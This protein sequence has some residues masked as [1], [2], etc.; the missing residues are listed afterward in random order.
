M[1]VSIRKTIRGMSRTDWLAAAVCLVLFS[2]YFVIIRRGIG[3]DD[4]SFYYTI[5]QRLSQGDRL[6]V[7]EWHVSQLSGLLLSVLYR[8][9]TAVTGGVDGILL[10]MRFVYAFCGFCIYWLLYVK[11]RR[12][13][14]WGLLAVA[15]FTIF[16]FF[17][18][19]TLNYITMTVQ[20]TAV[21]GA[22]VLADGRP[23]SVPTLLFAGI[24]LS[25]TVLA[26]PILAIA[27]LFY[28]VMVFANRIR[29]KCRPDSAKSRY[30]FILNVRVWRWIS[31]SVGACLIA[32]LL[33]LQIKSG[34]PNVI[35]NLP[36]L[37]TDSEY[38]FSTDGN[39]LFY[40]TK[41]IVDYLN[42]MY[43]RLPRWGLNCVWVASCVYTVLRRGLLQ[44]AS[45]GAQQ[46]Q[47]NADLHVRMLLLAA[48][49]LFFSLAFFR[50]LGVR[51]LDFTPIDIYSVAVRMYFCPAAQIMLFAWI[52]Y[53]LSREQSPHLFTNLSASLML[54][55]LTDYASDMVVA[56]GGVIAL[57]CAV[58]QFGILIR[59]MKDDVRALRTGNNH[60]FVR[61]RAVL[62]QCMAVCC[63]IAFCAWT[64]TYF[65]H[66]TIPVVEQ[67]FDVSGKRAAVDTRIEDGVYKGIY[68]TGKLNG[69]YQDILSD[70]DKIRA[71]CTG[72]VYVI[73]SKFPYL[74]MDL[75]YA[76]YSAW[77][78]QGDMGS[79]QVL[80]WL[81]NPSRK[82]QY[83]L[84]PDLDSLFDQPYPWYEVGEELPDYEKEANNLLRFLNRTAVYEI[85]QG[86]GGRILHIS[87]WKK[88][89]L[90]AEYL[91]AI[92][93]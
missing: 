46:T 40:S 29:Q 3:I 23:K 85:D 19:P 80:Y 88:G 53:N 15:S 68:T 89:A 14:T 43:G 77:Y 9:F 83:I 22:L 58:P 45:G 90:E 17:L 82:P 1:I 4:E 57:L 11:M 37:V 69:L 67:R 27:Y 31:L 63:V 34:I 93:H 59:E 56:L 21:F 60:L 75:P 74:Y 18:M 13:G 8:L 48:G 55:V 20:G 81:I 35:R 42:P 44:R 62:M 70:C 64:G 2:F 5:P 72:S 54:S 50:S 92:C 7:D 41:K 12:Y 47:S 65:Y 78:V 84:L 52:C 86:R 66:S 61:F 87:E 10:F 76:A 71:Q 25:C 28:S 91:N 16:S 36:N 49:C 51:F 39:R 79:R 73:Q 33:Y 38:D 30:D 32:F 6:L 24:V 26:E